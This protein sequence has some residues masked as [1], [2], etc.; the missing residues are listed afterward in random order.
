MSALGLCTHRKLVTHFRNSYFK[1]KMKKGYC[2][3]FCQKMCHYIKV[4]IKQSRLQLRLKKSELTI[5]NILNY[6]HKNL[7]LS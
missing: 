4:D 1:N 3:K 6:H 2:N 7:D 5:M